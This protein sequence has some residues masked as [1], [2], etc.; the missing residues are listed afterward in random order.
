M[1]QQSTR[2]TLSCPLK[3]D[4]WFNNPNQDFINLANSRLYTQ[5]WV[6]GLVTG[7][8]SSSSTSWVLVVITSGA[9]VLG[10][11]EPTLALALCP[12]SVAVDSNYSSPSGW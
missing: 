1:K 3:T 10:V 12:L 7:T 5:S 6:P 8:V 4:D 9:G 2:H 11:G